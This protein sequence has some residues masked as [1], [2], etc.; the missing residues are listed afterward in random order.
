[1]QYSEYKDGFQFQNTMKTTFTDEE[2]AVLLEAY[3]KGMKSACAS[4]IKEVAE[5]D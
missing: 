5:S 2:R 1:M 3:E 4:A